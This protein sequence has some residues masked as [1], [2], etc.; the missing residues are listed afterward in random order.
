VL[1]QVEGRYDL[2]WRRRL[3][4]S[5]GCYRNEDAAVFLE[6]APVQEVEEGL[7]GCSGGDCGEHS[8]ECCPS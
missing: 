5:L 4:D 8:N 2:R 6:S 1:L 3:V 7:F